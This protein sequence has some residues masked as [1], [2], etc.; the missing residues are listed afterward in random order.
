M[1]LPTLTTLSLKFCNDSLACT[2]CSDR[3]CLFVTFTYMRNLTLLHCLPRVLAVGCSC[4]QY[5]CPSPHSGLCTQYSSPSPR[6]ALCT[7]YSSPSPHTALSTKY[8][9]PFPHP[10]LWHEVFVSVSYSWLCMLYSSPSQSRLCMQYSSPSPHSGLCSM[11]TIF[12]SVSSLSSMYAIFDSVCS[13][14]SMYA[15]FV[16]LLIHYV[17]N[18]CLRLPPPGCNEWIISVGDYVDN[19]FTALG[20]SDPMQGS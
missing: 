10:A 8:S 5:S 12:V 13:S 18:I 19:S 2:T 20:S 6:S 4:A 3:C 17:R 11:Y 7:K 14:N 15:I 16:C 9:S 1:A